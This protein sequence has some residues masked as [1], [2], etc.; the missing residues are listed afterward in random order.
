[1][2]AP[3]SLQHALSTKGV[4]PASTSIAD[5]AARAKK[6]KLSIY[7]VYECALTKALSCHHL[8]L[9]TAK[10]WNRHHAE[11]ISR[12]QKFMEY[13]QCVSTSAALKTTHA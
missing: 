10:L 11:E 1:M 5:M 4:A 13:E 3:I 2:T 9:Q 7:M 6:N 12:F 8:L